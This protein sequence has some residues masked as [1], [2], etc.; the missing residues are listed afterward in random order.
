MLRW[1]LGRAKSLRSEG[2]AVIVSLCMY[3]RCIGLSIV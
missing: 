2:A 3:F 1:V